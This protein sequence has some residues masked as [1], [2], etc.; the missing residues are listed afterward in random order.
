MARCSATFAKTR[1]REIRG[2]LAEPRALFLG[3]EDIG[4][5]IAEVLDP[6]AMED[7]AV[8]NEVGLVDWEEGIID[9]NGLG[10]MAPSLFADEGDLAGERRRAVYRLRAGGLFVIWLRTSSF[11]ETLVSEALGRVAGLLLARELAVGA[12]RVEEALG[13]LPVVVVVVAVVR[14]LPTVPPLLSVGLI[15]PGLLTPLVPPI[16][17]R[18]PIDPTVDDPAPPGPESVSF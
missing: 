7:A 14:V 4:P 5:F 11:S 16:G 13:R 6:N 18:V 17:R 8:V 10:N 9:F 3:D 15:L 12:K 2:L 1:D